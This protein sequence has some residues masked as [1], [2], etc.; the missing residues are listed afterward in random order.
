MPRRNGAMTMSQRSH[1]AA[2][3]ESYRTNNMHRRGSLSPPEDVYQ[4]Y[5]ALPVHQQ[6]SNRFQSRS[7]TATPT[8][9]PKKRQ[10]PQ[11]PPAAN[12]SVMRDRL[13]Q[14]FDERSGGRFSRYRTRQTHHTH[15]QA[16]YRSTGMGGWERHY[17]GLSDSDLTM[18]SVETR[19]RP[20]HSMSPDKD[21]LGDFGDS[22]MESVV[23][24]TSSAF[25]TQSERPRGSRGIR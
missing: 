10:L 9:S 15:H 19:L 17:T 5:S 24:V 16:T 6:Y 13:T 25:S 8:G 18:H 23:S 7:A 3:S 4:D 22:D 14:D 21:F 20:R 11:I 2:P 12:R 1:S